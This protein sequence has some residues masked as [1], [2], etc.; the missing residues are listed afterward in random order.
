MD[1]LL[2]VVMLGAVSKREG[3]GGSARM[4][5]ARI[6][7]LNS[8]RPGLAPEGPFPYLQAEPMSTLSPQSLLSTGL[9]WTSAA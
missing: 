1:P 2:E 7:Q 4:K 5:S 8:L 9:W 6:S 3:L